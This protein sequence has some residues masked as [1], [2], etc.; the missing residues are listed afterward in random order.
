VVP[1]ALKT[2]TNTVS[3]NLEDETAN[4]VLCT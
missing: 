1:Y 4:M 2:Y 3:D